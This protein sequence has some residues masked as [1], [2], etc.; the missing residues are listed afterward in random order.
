MIE[1]DRQEILGHMQKGRDALCGALAGVD[2]GLALRKPCANR[3]SILECV[4]HV[5]LTERY[6]FSRLAQASPA[7]GCH[8]DAARETRILR[9]GPDRSQPMASPEV[10]QPCGQFKTL[11]EALTAFDLARAQTVQFV[12]GFAGD[13]RSFLTD[14]PLFPGPLNCYEMLLILAVHP[15]RHAKQ[16]EEVRAA[17]LGK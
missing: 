17:T 12:E 15:A 5:A 1:S 2:E 14:H 7:D 10:A 13:P 16:I 6:L 9:R 11:S 8:G 3:W 4:E